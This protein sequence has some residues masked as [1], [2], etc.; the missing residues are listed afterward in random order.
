VRVVPRSRAKAAAQGTAESQALV[1]L[2]R[3]AEVA[4]IVPAVTAPPPGRG[5]WYRRLSPRQVTGTAPLFPLA[6]LFGLNAVDELD[7]TAF[8]VLTPEIRD[9]FGLSVTGVTV[10]TVAVLPVALLVELPV[11]FL[12]D[13]RNRTR[14]AAG[15]AALWAGFT[16]LTG[17]AGLL[18]SLTLLY[19]ARGGSALG[20]T[21]NATH[22]SLLADYYPQEARARVFYAHRL[23][24][25]LGQ[26]VGPLVAGILAAVFTWETPF[27]VL[28]LP[29]VVFVFLGLRLREPVRGVHERRAAGADESTAE[30]EEVPAGFTETFRTL[31]ASQSARR[32]YL[33]LPF[34]TASFL[35][36]TSLLSLFYEEVYDV[37]SAGRGVIFA[38]SEPAQIIGLIVGAVVVQRVMS[39]DPGATMRLLG[40]S[41]IGSAICM[42]VVALS[43]AIG[44]AIAGQIGDAVLRSMLVPGIF[45]VISLAVPARMRTLGFATGSLWVLLGLPILPIVGAFGDRYGLRVAILLLIPVYLIGSFL[46]ASAGPSLNADIARQNL[47]SRTQAEIRRRRLEGDPQVLVV[48]DLDVAYDSTQV[49]FGVDLEVADGEIVALLGT[50]GAGKS[51]LLRAISG[52]ERSTAGAVIF[53]GRDVSGADAVQTATLGMT[54][55]PGERGTFPSL[56]VEE[57]LRLAGWLHRHDPAHVAAATEAVLEHFPVLRDRWDLPAGSLSGGEQQMLSLGSAFIA[58]PKLLM[59]DE[60]S[61]GLAPTVVAKLLAI[62]PAIQAQ[63]TAILLVEQSVNTALQ[64]ADRAVFLEKG[65]VRFSGPTSELLERTDILRSVFLHGAAAAIDGNGNGRA[66]L[67]ATPRSADD[68]APAAVVLEVDGL[69]KRYGGITAVNDVNFTLREGEVLGLIGP[70]GAGK[71]TVFDLVSGFQRADGGRVVLEGVDVTGASA[72]ERARLG[73][74]RSFQSARLWPSLTVREALATGLEASVDVRAALPAMLNLPLVRDSED[75]VMARV[76]E[77]LELLAIGAWADRFVSE[78]STGVRRMVD[79]GVQLA[80]EPSVLLLDEPSSGIAAKETEAL[81]PTLKA[82]QRHL[83]CSL[84]LIEHDMPLVRSLADRLV[85]LDTGAVVAEGRPDEVLAH[86]RVVESYLG[87]GWVATP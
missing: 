81:G 37:G 56:T 4:G 25:S 87:E 47:S 42:A 78:L 22:N 52:L 60:L 49:L 34:F 33:S 76:D 82:V 29:T 43:P 38:M 51:T 59:I 40:F 27:F 86:P 80:N 45:A 62:L 85:A 63:G 9:A 6:V 75:R 5:P 46:L 50:N 71:T 72:H 11:A 44:F 79:L 53:D 68:A 19:I 14:M 77:L 64:A 23:A 70:N 69:R 21:F 20:K 18:S 39:K 48:R 84:L 2:E 26:F 57:N 12:A 7:R 73:L 36:L 8:A 13:R 28:A 66:P 32:I 83:G 58:K 67:P 24:N 17:I 15:G 3:S 35:G 74:G 10:L 30:I 55:V 54:Q 61:L 65:S 16:L 31:F 41:A 1:D